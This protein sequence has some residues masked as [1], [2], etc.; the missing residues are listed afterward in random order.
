[1]AA[2]SH[3]TVEADVPFRCRVVAVDAHHAEVSLGGELDLANSPLLRTELL[4]T[5]ALGCE[6][7]TVDLGALTFLDSSGISVLVVIR[8]RAME[9]G[10][11]LQLVS[12]PHAVRLVLDRCGLTE[13]FELDPA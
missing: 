12:V 13:L 5:L 7:L 6:H 1:M 9:T 2:S 8:K 10:G 11:S 4:A 3:P